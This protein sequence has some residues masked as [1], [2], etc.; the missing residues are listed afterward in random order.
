M[1]VVG[2]E[3]D[4]AHGAHQVGGGAPDAVDP[5]F[6][7]D[8]VVK[9]APATARLGG[10]GVADVHL[11]APVV[12]FQVAAH[13]G[14]LAIAGGG[15]VDHLSLVFGAEGAG[16]GQQVHGLQQGGL[17]LGVGSIQ[18]HHAGRQGQV[19]RGKVA[20]VGQDKA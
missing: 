4:G 14:L 7:A 11:N 2:G 10:G 6:L 9:A 17:A 19:Q 13:Q 5:D 18:H 12:F 8:G 16:N 3:E 20:E 15:E 1:D